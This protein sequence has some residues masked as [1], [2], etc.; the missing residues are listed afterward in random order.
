[1]PV[2]PVSDCSNLKRKHPYHAARNSGESGSRS[3]RLSLSVDVVENC[4]SADSLEAGMRQR[5]IRFQKKTGASGPYLRVVQRGNVF[6]LG[7][8]PQ[9]SCI[10]EFDLEQET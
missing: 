3:A 7:Y 4:I 1:L 9:G 5:H 2:A 6:S 8:Y 10:E